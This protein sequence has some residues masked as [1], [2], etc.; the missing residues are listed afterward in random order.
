VHRKTT[1][2]NQLTQPYK[3]IAECVYKPAQ[4]HKI[5][6]KDAY[7]LQNQAKYKKQNNL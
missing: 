7:K 3:N 4:P 6:A 5:I 2:K 1:P